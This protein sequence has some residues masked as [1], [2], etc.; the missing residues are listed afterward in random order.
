M[1]FLRKQ[2][3]RIWGI[4]GRMTVLLKTSIIQGDCL[5]KLLKVYQNVKS[6]LREN[7]YFT[8]GVLVKNPYF[9]SQN[10]HILR[11]STYNGQI[12]KYRIWLQFI[13]PF[14]DQSGIH[15]YRQTDQTSLLAILV[16]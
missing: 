3:F 9:W 6:R 8:F 4:R 1:Q 16:C 2:I 7:S 13:Q 5:H 15:T 11:A 10:V 14:R 12:L